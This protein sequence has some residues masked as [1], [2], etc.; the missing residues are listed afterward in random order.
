MAVAGKRSMLPYQVPIWGGQSNKRFGTVT[1]DGYMNFF[2]ETLPIVDSNTIT[3][4]SDLI[5]Y[6]EKGV[7]TFTEDLDGVRIREAVMTTQPYNEDD[8]LEEDEILVTQE[9]EEAIMSIIQRVKLRI[10]QAVF[11][12]QGRTITSDYKTTLEE[13][14]KSKL[15]YMKNTEKSLIELS[16]EG[17]PAYTV[18][19]TVVPR[20]NQKKGYV[21]IEASITPV[22]A[23][24]QISATIYVR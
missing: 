16:S 5:E 20:S 12:M 19:A 8:E 23:A 17:L 21:A 14:I 13:S 6:N 15:E 24:R 2:V 18:S 3:T 10:W 9:T 11:A 7:I 4:K 1:P 22:H